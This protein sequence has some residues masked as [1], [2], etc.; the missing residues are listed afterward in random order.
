[1]RLKFLA[2]ITHS[3][4][5]HHLSHKIENVLLFNWKRERFYSKIQSIKTYLVSKYKS[6]FPTVCES[7]Q[8]YYC[9]RI[10]VACCPVVYIKFIHQ[11]HHLNVA[12]ILS[13]QKTNLNVK[14]S[15]FLFI[16]IIIIWKFWMWP[17]VR[18]PVRFTVTNSR[19]QELF[20]FS[21]L[22]H[23]LSVT[24]LPFP[25]HFIRRISVMDLGC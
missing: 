23:T 3:Q 2:M 19:S 18:P 6:L 24:F 22:L 21:G 20:F 15:S 14:L 9:L 8:A 17:T 10:H 5:A 25:F 4:N 12:F 13:P 1:M 16:E 11:N 7:A